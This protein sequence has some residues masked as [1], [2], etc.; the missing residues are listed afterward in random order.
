MEFT[1]FQTSYKCC[2]RCKCLCGECHPYDNNSGESH[3]PTKSDLSF[4]QQ[5]LRHGTPTKKW[6]GV[7]SEKKG[8]FY[9]I[10]YF[11]SILITNYPSLSGVSSWLLKV[12]SFQK[13]HVAHFYAFHLLSMLNEHKHKRALHYMGAKREQVH[14]LFRLTSSLFYEMRD[15]KCIS[16]TIQILV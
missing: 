14:P 6:P 7:N 12:A 1:L 15:K 5:N 13:S 11:L 9:S 2:C 16:P 3:E 4:R 10:K 8:A